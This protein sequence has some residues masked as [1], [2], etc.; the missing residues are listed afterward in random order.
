MKTNPE[1]IARRF[2]VAQELSSSHSNSFPALLEETENGRFTLTILEENPNNI[3]FEF[4]GSRYIETKFFLFQDS[5]GSSLLYGCRELRAVTGSLRIETRLFSIDF[6][7]H[8]TN[9]MKLD[10]CAG[11]MKAEITGLFSFL[12]MHV[13]ES[14]TEAN[15]DDRS[16][17]NSWSYYIVNAEPL[18]LEISGSHRLELAAQGS[19]TYNE[20]PSHLGPTV[21]LRSQAIVKNRTTQPMKWNESFHY[22]IAIRDLLIVSTG[23]PQ[24]IV[25]VQTCFDIATSLAEE[26]KVRLWHDVVGLD[27]LEQV[28]EEGA[29]HH[30]LFFWK[31]IGSEGMRKWLDLYETT[32]GRRVIVTLVRVLRSKQT[33]TFNEKL[34]ALGVAVDA[35]GQHLAAG[36]NENP[37]G[38]MGIKSCASQIVNFLSGVVTKSVFSTWA[39]EFSNAYNAIKHSDMKYEPEDFSDLRS[40]QAAQFLRLALAK[41]IGVDQE[42]LL[43]VSRHDPQHPANF[44]YISHPDL[45][46]TYQE[47]QI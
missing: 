46:T 31:D 44:S 12:E 16:N 40:M 7:I 6:V 25:S 13:I 17:P 38:Q 36:A 43:N 37:A 20:R 26:E 47:K 5:E 14:S 29:S 34:L 41:L 23:L 35:L 39:A 4:S 27:F 42:T 15:G 11:D 30:F 22:L 32:R 21:G 18:Q 1:I 8:K 10:G 2:G 19:I 28:P 3:F 9:E 45:S 24:T 33:T